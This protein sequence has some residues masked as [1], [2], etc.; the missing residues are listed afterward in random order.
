MAGPLE[1]G[2]LSSQSSPSTAP[3]PRRT[4][5]HTPRPASSC[6]TIVWWRAWCGASTRAATIAHTRSRSGLAREAISPSK[7]SRCMATRTAC[8]CPCG[9]ERTTSKSSSTGRRATPASTARIA[10]ICSSESP[11]RLASV[12]LRTFSPSPAGTWAGRRGSGRHRCAR[13]QDRT[14]N[15]IGQAKAHHCTGRHSAPSEPLF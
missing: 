1:D 6:A 14:E 13:L 12:R 4:P 5:R 7:P 11:E 9:R 2:C 8:T 10:S 3:P 15:M